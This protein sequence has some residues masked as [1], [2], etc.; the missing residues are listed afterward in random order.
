MNAGN[1]VVIERRTL[2]DF[3]VK[4]VSFEPRLDKWKP[5]GNFMIHGLPWAD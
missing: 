4:C 1:Y 5:V 3:A 2:G